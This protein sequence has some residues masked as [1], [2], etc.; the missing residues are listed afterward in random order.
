MYEFKNFLGE[1]YNEFNSI[2]N[3]YINVHNNTINM[4]ACVSLPYKEVADIQSLPLWTL[5]TEGTVGKRYFPAFKSLDDIEIYGEE[6]TL[7]LFDLNKHDYAVSLQP[8]SGTQ[9]NQIVFNAILNDGDTVLS[10]SP[11]DG[12]HVSH[13]KLGCRN[14][15]VVY[16]NL[17][18]NNI[19]QMPLLK[20]L[21][22]T[23]KPKLVI[24]GGSSYPREHRYK[25]ISE[26][27]HANGA[28]L[29]ADICHSVLYII[30]KSH[31]PIFPYVDF[32]TFTMDKTMRGP[33]G[34]II[35]YKNEFKKAIELSVF[36]KTQGGPLQSLLFSKCMCLLKSTQ[37]DMNKYS[38][39]VITNARIVCKVLSNNDIDIVSNGTDTHIVLIDLRK[40]GL[41]GNVAETLLYQNKILV[42][43]NQIPNDT[44]SAVVSSGIR[45][46]LTPITNIGYQDNDVM[47]LAKCIADIIKRQSDCSQ[48]I[49]KL[50]KK[51]SNFNISN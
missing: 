41:T 6:L 40:Y 51:Y 7:K 5:P 24:V 32:A 44:K 29:M 9:A 1:K 15:N 14:I 4:T 18:E 50:I 37:C 28:L 47:V 27:A 30:G 49:N 43:R 34:G 16:Y 35:I 46:G 23:H 2:V 11:K 33:Q 13:S 39:D 3:D 31:K 21:I 26:I 36:P 45:I 12:G 8:N 17:D 38:Q 48:I 10:L 19:L 22:I 25:E 20:K 42:N